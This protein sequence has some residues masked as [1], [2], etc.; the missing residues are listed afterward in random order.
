MDDE[1]DLVVA[2]IGVGFEFVRR[3]LAVSVR[4]DHVEVGDKGR[5]LIRVEFVPL[6]FGQA[7]NGL[8]LPRDGGQKNSPRRRSRLRR[9]AHQRK[10][11]T[12]KAA[13]HN[14]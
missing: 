9:P 4:V 5:S 10:R 7:P 3:D 2:G 14:P 13:A 1:A 8:T 11:R 6:P 12:D